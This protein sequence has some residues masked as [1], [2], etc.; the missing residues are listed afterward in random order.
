MPEALAPQLPPPT[1]KYPL[2]DEKEFTL[3]QLFLSGRLKAEVVV[4]EKLKA[5][6]QSLLT[7]EIHA[8]D[9]ELKVDQN[10]SVRDYNNQTALKQLSYALVAINGKSVG[11]TPKERQAWVLKQSAIVSDRLLE[12]Y[13]EFNNRANDLFKPTKAGENVLKKS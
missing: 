2:S 7:E 3:D 12:A 13:L 4:H 11:A 6:L 9:S 5:T 10:T 1:Y 8:I